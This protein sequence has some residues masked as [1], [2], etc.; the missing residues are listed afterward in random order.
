VDAAKLKRGSQALLWDIPLASSMLSDQISDFFLAVSSRAQWKHFDLS[1][2]SVD[3]E[4]TISEQ[5]VFDIS[6]ND[7]GLTIV[8]EYPTGGIL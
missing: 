6:M 2:L 5:G 1:S 4:W 8:I 7:V 3:P